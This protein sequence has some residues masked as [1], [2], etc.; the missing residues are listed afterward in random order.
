MEIL[1]E[2]QTMDIIS[3]GRSASEYVITNMLDE[4][5]KKHPGLYRFIYGEPSD[6]IAEINHDMANL[7]LDLSCDVLWFFIKGFGNPPVTGSEKWTENHI[8]LIDGE[9][10]S[11]SDE[12]PMP[13]RVRENLQS[14]FVQRS[15]ETNIQVELMVYLN[16]EVARYSSF[17]KS[18]VE[19]SQITRNFLFVLVRLMGD[20]YTEKAKA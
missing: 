7:Y 15:I 20:L 19:A 11:L 9:L 6:A 13:D 18:R 5:E 4:F 1:S 10:K 16:C 12:I 3:Q 17:N 2:R 14:R 8:A